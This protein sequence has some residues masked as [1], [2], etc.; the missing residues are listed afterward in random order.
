MM[1]KKT[2]HI[3]LFATLATMLIAAILSKVDNGWT[4]AGQAIIIIAAFVGMY[5]AIT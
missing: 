4:L 1:K 3:A 5:L 2:A